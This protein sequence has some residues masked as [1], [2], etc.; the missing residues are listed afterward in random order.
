MVTMIRTENIQP[1]MYTELHQSKNATNTAEGLYCLGVRKVSH[2][3]TRR[4]NDLCLIAL[5]FTFA[6]RP[7]QFPDK[8][9]ITSLPFIL[10]IR[11]SIMPPSVREHCASVWTLYSYITEIVKI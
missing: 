11:V 10:T 1:T 9:Y 4:E 2:I 7:K 3:Q 6:Q 8:E 5:V